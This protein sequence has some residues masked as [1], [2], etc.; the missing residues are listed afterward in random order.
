M[1]PLILLF[2]ILS[3][4]NR[5]LSQNQKTDSLTALNSNST[6]DLSA[7]K[8]QDSIPYATL[9]FYRSF[10]PKF[11]APIKKIPLYI[12]YS[13]VY[14]LKANMMI[15][16]KVFEEGKFNIAIDDKAKSEITIKVKFGK[17]YFF[18]CEI[19]KGLWFG[20][21]AIEL[22]TPVIGKAELGNLK[23]EL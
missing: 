20:K 3:F 11:N 4:S 17:E 13:L 8:N 21:P 2:V 7:L 12:N 16:L 22:V 1:K 19:V 10:I 6:N 14:K 18:K 9:Y 23:T 15:A 5:G